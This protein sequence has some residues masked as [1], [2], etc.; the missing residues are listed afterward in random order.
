[1]DQ[2]IIEIDLD[3]LGGGLPA[4]QLLNKQTV[5]FE[6]GTGKKIE[7]FDFKWDEL[8][9]CYCVNINGF[10]PVGNGFNYFVAILIAYYS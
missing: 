4:I 6:V 9:D 5:R 1:M 3:Q 10:L 2:I 8:L 7:V